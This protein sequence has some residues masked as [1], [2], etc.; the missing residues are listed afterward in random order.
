MSNV[1]SSAQVD[2]LS[3]RVNG[4]LAT[5]DRQGNPNTAPIYLLQPRDQSTLL[6]CLATRHQTTENLKTQGRFS[7][8]ILEEGDQAFS[9]QGRAKL[10]RQPMDA[11]PHMALFI[12]HVENVKSDTTPTVAVLRGVLTEPRS[13]KTTAFFQAC[14]EEMER[15]PLQQK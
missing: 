10:V 5:V 8:S 3:R 6:L 11:N 14:F 2:L 15:L 12:L 9:I 4:V 1:L 7:L 13:D